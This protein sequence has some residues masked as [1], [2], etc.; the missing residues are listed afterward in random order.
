MT[1][2]R[3]ESR[4]SP[5]VAALE[6]LEAG[7]S[8]SSIKN[9]GTKAAA[10]PWKEF[11]SRRMTAEEARRHFPDHVGVGII[12]GAISGNLQVIDFEDERA[13]LD[14]KGL[15]EQI[16]PG[17]LDKL[18][19]VKTPGGGFHLFLRCPL[20]EGCQKIARSRDMTRGKEGLIIEAKAEG[21]YVLAPGSP[22]ACHPSGKTYEHVA[23]PPIVKTPII[24]V[25]ERQL[26]FDAARS[27]NEVAEYV[28]EG[29][30]EFAGDA[31]G[32]LRPGDD[33]NRRGT[34]DFLC[35]ADWKSR[36][37]NGTGRVLVTRPGKDPRLGASGTIGFCR[38]AAGDDLF[39]VFSSNAEPFQAGRA[40]SRFSAYALLHH[41]GDFSAAARDLAEKG[42]G[43]QAGDFK[44]K[45]KSEKSGNDP[46]ANDPRIAVPSY[47]PFPLDAL[48]TPIRRY[49]AASAETL[50][51]DPAF[52]GLPVLVIIA[53]AIGNSRRLRLTR[54]WTEPAVIWGGLVGESGTRKSPALDLVTRPV[55]R[56]Q[57]AAFKEWEAERRSY[58]RE[59]AE[60]ERAF[61]IWKRLK[62][63]AGEPPERP[64]EPHP[65]RYIVSDTTTEALAAVLADNPRGLLLARDELSAWL[66][67]FDRYA[68]GRADVPQWLELHRAGALTVDRRGGD[69]RIIF[70]PRAVVSLVGSIQPLILRQ[71][72]IPEYFASGLAARLLVT[73]PPQPRRRWTERDVSEDVEAGYSQILDRLWTLEP[74]EAPDGERY[75][76]DVCLDPEAKRL[77]IEF[78]N[79]HEA[80]AEGLPEALMAAW[81]KL[82]GYCARL[83]L[84]LHLARWAG[85]ETVNPD[86]VDADSMGSAIQLARWLAG[87]A[88]RVYAVLRED[89]NQREQRQLLD[90]IRRHGEEMTARDLTHCSR[91]FRGRPEAAAAALAALAK[92]G[93]G[94]WTEQPSGSA[95]GR[96][97]CVFRLADMSTVPETPVVLGTGDSIGKPQRTAAD[98]PQP[99]PAAEREVE[100]L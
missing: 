30:K 34:W 23:G 78:Y 79:A 46:E 52:V 97:T 19:L 84:V 21:G 87:E 66:G 12:G 11:Q 28:E 26:L 13:F 69:R 42:Y 10:I 27:L 71:A 50:S 99:E 82:E 51:V 20:I 89:D 47:A 36:G 17:L 88:E 4:P 45:L 62:S 18:P 15:V 72:L 24:S 75:P 76:V 43:E 14:F 95:G 68:R 8:V 58:E 81:A 35:S 91:R 74:A 9:D 67:S 57:A 63:G 33:F 39:Y 59:L 32:R 16:C 94:A 2:T 54:S 38:N 98:D 5:L 37:A 53:S 93:L 56:R 80:E 44:P 64:E 73:M 90:L 49:V 3:T 96:P 92:A 83:A 31:G 7:F 22:A 85:G 29:P 77:W 1:L 100:Y 61:T 65:V 25:E 60:Y 6:Y 70:V 48:P 86:F 55:R 40:Y 41:S